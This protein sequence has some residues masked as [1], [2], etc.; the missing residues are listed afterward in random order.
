MR[1]QVQACHGPTGLREFFVT[2]KNMTQLF[3][4]SLLESV[5]GGNLADESNEVAARRLG[6]FLEDTTPETSTSGVMHITEDSLG[7]TGGRNRFLCIPLEGDGRCWSGGWAKHLGGEQSFRLWRPFFEETLERFPTV[8]YRVL[9]YE[10]RAPY[11]VA[12]YQGTD[13][14]RYLQA[15]RDALSG[16]DAVDP[17]VAFEASM[18]ASRSSLAEFLLGVLDDVA[19]LHDRGEIHGDIKP[20]N[21]LASGAGSAL[22][23]TVDLQ[24]GSTSPSITAGWSPPEQLMRL[25]LSFTADVYTLGLLFLRA[26]GGQKLGRI[27]TYRMPD[28]VQAAIVEDPAVYF[29]AES[30]I[31]PEEGRFQWAAVLETALRS[32]PKG[33]QKDARALGNAVREVLA[34]HAPIGRVSF[35][36]PWGKRPLLTQ[37]KGGRLEP[38]W[39]FDA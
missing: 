4:P 38:T 21:V 10:A 6:W 32:D 19:V 13:Q 5:I 29:G 31:V 27:V 2:R 28:G 15:W 8:E 35:K 9:K 3:A 23:D 18:T 12:L 25:P 16:T 37:A 30:Q 7:S 39:V 11:P 24:V 26:L 22:I 36:F 1:Q 20:S 17:T 33:R 34:V 14:A